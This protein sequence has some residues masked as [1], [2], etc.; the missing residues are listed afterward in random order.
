MY[1]L[2]FDKHVLQ[3]DISRHLERGIAAMSHTV[4]ANR[5]A[6]GRVVFRTP[7]GRWSLALAEAG[8]APS[9][10]EAKPLLDAALGDAAAQIIVDPYLIEVDRTGAAPRPVKLREAIRA[11]GPTIAYAPE[12]L[13]EAAE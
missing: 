5:L 4:T 3:S 6:D 2:I 10:A 9:E 11:F 8:F 1:L 12:A 7:E 13:L